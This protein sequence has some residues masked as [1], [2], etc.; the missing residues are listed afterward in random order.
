MKHIRS[1]YNR[2][3]QDNDN[4]IPEDE[5]VFLLRGQDFLAPFLLEEYAR[6]MRALGHGY[7]SDMIRDHAL[8]M[9]DWQDRHGCKIADCPKED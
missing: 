7:I 1:D 4:L 3:I 6:R 8:N 9:L 2:R 5:P